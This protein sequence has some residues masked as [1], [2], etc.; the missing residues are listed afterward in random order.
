MKIDRVSLVD[1]A[2]NGRTFLLFKRSDGG[3][4]M[5]ELKKVLTEIQAA[6][7]KMV[8]KVECLDAIDKRLEAL[9]KAAKASTEMVL[10]EKA[11]AKF[12]SS[13]L[14]H[15]R[16]IRA[17]IDRLLEGISD[18]DEKESKKDA[19]G[20]DSPE[21]VAKAFADSM[22][23]IVNPGTEEKSDAKELMAGLAKMLE[24]FLNKK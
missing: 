3:E 16:S 24:P 14:S 10:V 19:G 11:G 7:N 23:A 2:A 9:E 20:E 18:S 22:N 15:L 1:R 13:N 4:G 5:E 8:D 12:S 6:F 21:V 17:A